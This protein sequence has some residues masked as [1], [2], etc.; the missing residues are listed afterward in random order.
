MEIKKSGRLTYLCYS[1]RWVVI[2]TRQAETDIWQ[3]SGGQRLPNGNNLC[4]LGS[5]SKV[6]GLGEKW[7]WNAQGSEKLNGIKRL[8]FLMPIPQGWELDT[9]HKWGDSSP[10]RLRGD[11]KHEGFKFFPLKFAP[12]NKNMDLNPHVLSCIPVF[13]TKH[14]LIHN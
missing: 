4:G 8:F 13:L 14:A 1:S 6:W 9:P 12:N 2:V 5:C 11:L 7:R 10:L 3:R